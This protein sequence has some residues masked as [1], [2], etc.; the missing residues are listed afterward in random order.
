MRFGCG[1]R[2]RALALARASERIEKRAL[3]DAQEWETGYGEKI[4]YK[5]GRK[6]FSRLIESIHEEYVISHCWLDSQLKET[7]THTTHIPLRISE[8]KNKREAL[9]RAEGPF[10]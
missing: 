4:A 1:E 8:K 5:G 2:K 10:E 9:S 3:A 6:K 7:T